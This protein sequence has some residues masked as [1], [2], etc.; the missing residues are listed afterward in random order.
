M[1]LNWLNFAAPTRNDSFRVQHAR[2][3]GKYHP[4]LQCQPDGDIV[5]LDNNHLRLVQGAGSKVKFISKGLAERSSHMGLRG[6]SCVQST[7]KRPI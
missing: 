3:A 7:D 4:L 1:I 5:S 6:R 2:N